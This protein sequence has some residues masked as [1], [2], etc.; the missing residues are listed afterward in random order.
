LLLLLWVVAL[1]WVSLLR[2]VIALLWLTGV[3][4]VLWGALVV[5]V[6]GLGGLGRVGG[7]SVVVVLLGVGGWWALV[8]L[9]EMLVRGDLR[10]VGRGTYVFGCHFCDCRVV[11]MRRWWKRRLFYARK[12]E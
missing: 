3:E 6:V 4:L 8:I 9:L 7:T 11:K 12:A 5:I 2:W 1:L 10:I